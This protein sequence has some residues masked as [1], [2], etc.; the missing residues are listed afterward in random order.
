[1][2]L[3]ELGEKISGALSSLNK[4][5]VIDEVILK[6]LLSDICKALLEADINVR[7][8][9][10]IR[11]NIK[12][13][14]DLEELSAGTNKRKIIQ[15][16][17]FRELINMIDPGNDPYAMKKGEPN[18]IMFV[19]LQGSGKTT[20]IA[21]YANYYSKQGWKCAMVCADTFRAGAFDQLKQNARRLGVPFYGR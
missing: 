7:I 21:K 11:N 5:T 1:M 16:A 10:E 18:V 2:V 14:V 12:K 4:V 19:G 15:D 13:I 20:T 9:M 17:I 8:V 6:Q 3:G